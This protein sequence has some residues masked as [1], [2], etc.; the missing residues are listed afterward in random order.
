MIGHL[1]D[2]VDVVG[3]AETDDPVAQVRERLAP[4][5]RHSRLSVAIGDSTPA[6]FLLRLQAALPKVSFVPASEIM[7]PMRRVKDQEELRLLQVAQDVASVALT[8]LV[9]MPFAGR[10]ERQIALDLR[11]IC[12]DL[13][14]ESGF[15]VAVGSGP[16]GALPHLGP[17][18]RVIQ[19]GEAVVIDFWAAH[20]G[21]Y[22]DC[23]RTVF[24]GQ[25][26]EEFCRVFQIVREANHAALAA[27]RPGAPCQDVDRAARAVIEAAG[28]GPYF[29]HRL[30]HGLGIDV[31]EE[32]W[33]VEGNGLL[34]EPGMTFTDEPGIYLP[35]KF[36]CRIEDVVAVTETGGRLLTHFSQEIIT[37]R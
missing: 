31:H 34:L 22:S 33:I 35:G 24:V 11:R 27:V 21:Y 4:A 23:T 7:A 8:Q 19:E 1:S 6:I 9:Q 18:S 14:H 29:T 37:V 3:W 17:T 26:P 16:N 30:G 28:Y 15:G 13:G 2:W 10:T 32:P 5:D 25:P 20:Q 12:D 36:G